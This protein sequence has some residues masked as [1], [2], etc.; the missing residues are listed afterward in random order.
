MRVIR[1]GGFWVMVKLALDN[2]FVCSSGIS[3]KEKS[4]CWTERKPG[5]VTGVDGFIV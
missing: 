4:H 3:N 1:A 2:R 5:D